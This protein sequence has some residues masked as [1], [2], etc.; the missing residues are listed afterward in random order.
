M[1]VAELLV[2]EQIRHVVSSYND[3]GDRGDLAGLAACFAADGVLQIPD[4]D[5]M[6]GPDEIATV[7]PTILPDRSDPP[8]DRPPLTYL[9]HRVTNLHFVSIADDEVTTRAYYMVVTSVGPDHWGRYVDTFGRGSDGTWRIRHRRV[10]VDGY[11]DR[12]HFG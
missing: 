11:A 5:P 8:T 10:T 9:H 2:R 3:A 1:D 7:L 12:S 4:R 6:V